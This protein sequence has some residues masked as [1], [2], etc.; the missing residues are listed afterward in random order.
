MDGAPKLMDLSRDVETFRREI[1]DEA[2]TRAVSEII[3][4]VGK[5]YEGIAKVR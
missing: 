3:T 5:G 2:G 1:L 4:A